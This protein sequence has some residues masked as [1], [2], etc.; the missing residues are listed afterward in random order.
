MNKISLLENK[1]PFSLRNK[2]LRVVWWFVYVFVFSLTPPWAMN[3]FR[4]FIL[5]LFGAKIGS[6]SVI[7]PSVKIW[8]PWNLKMG[9]NSCIGPDSDIYSMGHISIGSDVTIS[10]GAVVC[11]GTHDI[12]TR[13]NDLQIKTVVIG[14]Q[15]WV[16]AYA[17]IMPGITINEGS[18]VGLGAVV[19]KDV[20]PW[21]VVAGN[22]AKILKKR[23]VLNE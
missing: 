12:K 2:V 7:Y 16:C 19:V 8:A 4:I 3:R 15:S 11:T 6:G 5:K 20:P 14:N 9:C 13:H 17:K 22:P 1:S 18:V 23:V 10:Q 21:V